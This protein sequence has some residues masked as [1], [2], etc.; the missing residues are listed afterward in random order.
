M[1][2]VAKAQ[3]KRTTCLPTLRRLCSRNQETDAPPPPHLE[4]FHIYTIE[5]FNKFENKL[6]ILHNAEF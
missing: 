3:V 2:V 1:W 4:S 6:S 5:L